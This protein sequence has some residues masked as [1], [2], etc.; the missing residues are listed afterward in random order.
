MFYSKFNARNPIGLVNIILIT[1]VISFAMFPQSSYGT[2][3]NSLTS[4]ARQKSDSEF[5]LTFLSPYTIANSPIN[6]QIRT[7]DT[8]TPIKIEVMSSTSTQ[9]ELFNFVEDLGARRV[10]D[11]LEI[12]FSSLVPDANIQNTYNFQIPVNGEGPTSLSMQGANIYPI[13]ISQGSNEDKLRT[14]YSFVTSVPSVGSDG[15]AFSQKLKLLNF[16]KFQ[17]VIDRV[18]MVDE[19]GN[20]SEKGLETAEL[21][22]STQ[23]TLIEVSNLNTANTVLINPDA[24]DGYNFL[25][26]IR[27][28]NEETQPFY[29]KEPLPTTEYLADTFV[30]INIAELEKQ[31]T[32]EEFANLLNKSRDLL[33]EEGIRAPGRTLITQSLTQ[34]TLKQFIDSGIDQV[35]VEDQ[36]FRNNQRPKTKFARLKSGSNSIDV[37]TYDTEIESKLPNSLSSASKANYLVAATSVIALEA[38]SNLRGFILPLNLEKL[39]QRTVTLYLSAIKNSPLVQAQTSSQF[40]N[41][42]LLDKSLSKQLEQADFPRK[43]SDPVN[44]SQVEETILFANAAS[45]VYE[46]GSIQFN[47][48]SWMKLSVFSAVDLKSS[49]IVN[50]EAAEKL[51]SDVSSKIELPKKRTLTI[52]SRENNIPVTIQKTTPET[53]NVTVRISSNRLLFPEGDSFPL[54]LEEENT[55]VTIPVKARTSGSFP[56]SIEIITPVESVIIAEQ[57]ATVRSTTLSGT[58]VFIA[59]GSIIFLALWWASHYKKTR[60]KAIAPVLQINKEKSG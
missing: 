57:T 1:V 7:E 2:K 43:V 28:S 5:S 8:S 24:I 39:D 20:L 36:T 19:D 18:S 29:V 42:D 40:F 10:R 56:I 60:K 11:T 58:G 35:I 46:T 53:L 54:E 51:V 34:D 26:D 4:N 31:G 6:A 16:L 25:N 44:K 41:Q 21:L 38:P 45:S 9:S 47:Q 30:P 15:A 32:N 50:P 3:N 17:P 12:P 33:K 55:T 59:V 23:Q 14:Q 13:A 52:T 48:A 22:D 49:K 37:A 27:G